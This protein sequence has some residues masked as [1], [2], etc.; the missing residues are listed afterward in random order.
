MARR[1]RAV[2]WSKDALS[3]LDDIW[4]YYLQVAGHD[5]AEKISREIH[6]IAGLLAEHPFA[7]RPRDE[8]RPGLRSL[9]AAP[10]ILFYRVK[11]DIPEIARVLDGRQ[12]IDQIFSAERP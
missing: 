7:G 9:I 1:N 10:H 3:D 11:R 4:S 5:T 12:D 8:I 2:I 6:V